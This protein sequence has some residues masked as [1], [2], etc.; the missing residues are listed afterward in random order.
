M[1][2]IFPLFSFRRPG[3]LNSGR[4]SDQPTVHLV[5]RCWVRDSNPGLRAP[6]YA[7][8]PSCRCQRSR[9]LA[10]ALTAASCRPALK[11]GVSSALLTHPQALMSWALSP[12]LLMQIN[13]VSGCT[14][15][16]PRNEQ[17]PDQAEMLAHL[18][19]A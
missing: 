8:S 2:S 12:L 4:V 7:T 10:V 5:N 1:K 6:H 14:P 13:L 19:H 18:L 9:P 11:S 17:N 3:K 16:S 15:P